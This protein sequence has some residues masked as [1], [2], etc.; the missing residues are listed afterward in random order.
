[1]P[2]LSRNFTASDE[3]LG[4]DQRQRD[5]ASV[6]NWSQR[7]GDKIYRKGLSPTVSSVYSVKNWP[8]VSDCRI[9]R[10]QFKF[11]GPEALV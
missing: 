9:A 6:V 5:V 10:E 11:I 1:M 8:A 4:R 3:I 2:E 7:G